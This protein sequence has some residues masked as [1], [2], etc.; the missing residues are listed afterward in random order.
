MEE[1]PEGAE[2][3]NMCADERATK[4]QRLAIRVLVQTNELHEVTQKPKNTAFGRH[5]SLP[6]FFFDTQILHLSNNLTSSQVTRLISAGSGSIIMVQSIRA[7]TLILSA[8][9]A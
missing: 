9:T 4:Q 8:M 5:H 7:T 3:W 1:Q 2:L 6:V